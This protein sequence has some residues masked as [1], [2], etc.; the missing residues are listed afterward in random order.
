[1][2]IAVMSAVKSLL[3]IRTTTAVAGRIAYQSV[4]IA[5]RPRA[6]VLVN[7]CRFCPLRYNLLCVRIPR[8]VFSVGS[9]IK[10]V[11]RIV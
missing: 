3:I 2:V 9:S 5:T 6:S 4:K 10:A 11:R 8:F 1:M 7:F